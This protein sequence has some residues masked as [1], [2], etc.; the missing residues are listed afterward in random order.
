MICPSCSKQTSDTAKFCKHCGADVVRERIAT[1]PQEPPTPAA[2]VCGCGALLAANAKFCT[3]C[4]ASVT[5]SQPSRQQVWQPAPGPQRRPVERSQ[6]VQSRTQG[7]P[8]PESVSSAVKNL[9][10]GGKIAAAGGGLALIGCFLPLEANA[11]MEATIVRGIG[12]VGQLVIVPL[13]AVALTV[14]ALLATVGNATRR[15]NLGGATI[16]VGSPWAVVLLV[17]I[18]AANKV[19]SGL[20]MFAMGA[21]VGVGML[22]LA[23]GFATGVVGGFMILNEAVATAIDSRRD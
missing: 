20:G 7:S 4:G 15:A 6:R 12:E 2:N 17:V 10:K 18:L 9:S 5:D 14:M 8:I 11:G 3:G 13:S 21:S 16:A 23:A 19:I 22:L 1:A